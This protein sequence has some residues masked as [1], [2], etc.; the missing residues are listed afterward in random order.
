[1]P[2]KLGYQRKEGRERRDN[3]HLRPYLLVTLSHAE[4][5]ERAKITKEECARRIRDIFDCK[6]ILV[7]KEAHTTEPGTFHYHI[8]IHC[9]NASRY[10]YLQKIRKAF[11]EFDGAS[12]DVATHQSF[13]TA[14]AYA[15]KN[16]E[17]R[18]DPIDW[19]LVREERLPRDRNGDPGAKALTSSHTS[20]RSPHLRVSSLF[21][22]R[23][24]Y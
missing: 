5:G 1:M 11:P 15:T 8:C 21:R 7:A 9:T 6:A 4:R 20:G 23:S 10:T 19:D 16:D 24:S 14:I 17:E 12:I 2:H 22:R 18:G 13:S 3:E